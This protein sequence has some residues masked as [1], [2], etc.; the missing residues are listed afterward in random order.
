MNR[1]LLIRYNGE[2]TMKR[3][4]F[5]K[6]AM[7]MQQKVDD[8]VESNKTI[9]RNIKDDL[10]DSFIAMTQKEHKTYYFNGTNASMINRANEDDLVD[11]L[12]DNSIEFMIFKDTVKLE[13]AKEEFSK[14]INEVD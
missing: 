9:P 1:Y 3:G 14:L 5:H 2:I 8:V 10:V 13:D 11:T 12:D 7:D 4:N 6:L